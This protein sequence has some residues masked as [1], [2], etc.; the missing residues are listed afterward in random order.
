MRNRLKYLYWSE[1]IIGIIYNFLNS[2]R[3]IYKSKQL[4]LPLLKQN[5]DFKGS[6]KGKRCF[7]LG[8]GP[9]LNKHD[10]SVL[11]HEFVITCNTAVQLG[12]FE[13]INP[14]CFDL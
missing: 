5:M 10:L 14:S 1:H 4:G 12:Q 13:A 3:F 11:K 7:V 6:L 2:V 8:N 9:S